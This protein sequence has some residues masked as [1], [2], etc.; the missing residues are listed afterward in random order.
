[1]DSRTSA[2][3]PTGSTPTE[4]RQHVRSS[5]ELYQSPWKYCGYKRYSAFLGFSRSF[6]FL[7]QFRTLNVRVLLAM[8][9]DIV[10]LEEEL[11]RIEETLRQASSNVHNGK[12]REVDRAVSEAE[13]RHELIWEIQEKIR[14]YN[15][16]IVLYERIGNQGPVATGD[17]ESVRNW[18][19]DYPTGVDEPETKYLDEINADDLIYVLPKL[20]RPWL[21]R[22]FCN[23]FAKSVFRRAPSDPT[24]MDD[25]TYLQ[26]KETADSV[27]AVL[28]L[29]LG[30]FMLIFP[31][32]I[33]NTIHGTNERL[34]VIS[35]FVVLFAALVFLGTAAKADQTLAAT[36]GY[37]AVLLV[38]LLVNG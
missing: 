1:M 2:T 35:A 12:L 28:M 29:P 32:W 14:R 16:H 38:F 7:R 9:D 31:L 36:T 15:K 33:L 17:I 3:Q 24:E 18:H 6:F 25:E 5:T 37:S 19:R 8:Q 13:Q 4:V 20:E 23:L 30:L 27:L 21:Q 10:E 22:Q 26:D 34:A 11:D